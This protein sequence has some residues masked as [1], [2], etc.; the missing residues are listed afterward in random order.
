M[1]KQIHDMLVNS[2]LVRIA[3]KLIEMSSPCIR[4]DTDPVN[5][6][7]IS[8]GASKIGGLPDLPKQMEWPCWHDVPL[9]FLAQ[10]NLKDLSAYPCCKKYLPTEGWLFFFYDSEQRTWGFDPND[11][12]SWRVIFYDGESSDIS[13]RNKPSDDFDLYQ[14]CIVSFHESVSFP[15]W[16]GSEIDALL[17]GEELD[18]YADFIE[19]FSESPLCCSENQ[20]LG[21]PNPMQSDMRLE[22]QL[23]TNGIYCGDAKGHLD[24]R[25]KILEPGAKDWLLLLQLDSDDGAEMMWGDYGRLYFWIREQDVFDRNFADVWMILLC[26]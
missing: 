18:S 23:V 10:I 25:R 11:K 20:I 4:L 8:V 12:D 14:P 6:E 9:A 26:G 5:E 7:D 13:R 24:K 16:N 19:A 17:I 3:D 22:C 15:E 1:K 2:G 21:H